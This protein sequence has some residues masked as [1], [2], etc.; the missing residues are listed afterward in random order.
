MSVRGRGYMGGGGSSASAFG[1]SFAT[2]SSPFGTAHSE[3]GYQADGKKFAAG[4][5]YSEAGVALTIDRG[6]GGKPGGGMHGKPNGGS[7]GSHGRGKPGGGY[8]GKPG[9]GYGGG[10]HGGRVSISL[11]VFAGGH[12]SAFA[13]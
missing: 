3:N 5:N 6:R 9:G 1:N 2:F 4:K 8:G 11:K 7:Y 13:H 12:S 10:N